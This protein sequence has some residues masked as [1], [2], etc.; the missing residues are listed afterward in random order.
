MSKEQ[1]GR[2]DIPLA[3]FYDLI[4]PSLIVE[5]ADFVAMRR[6]LGGDAYGLAKPGQ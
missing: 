1:Q 3:I 5:R 2:C 4:D 6:D